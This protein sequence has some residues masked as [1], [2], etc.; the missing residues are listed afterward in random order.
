MLINLLA[1]I[2][3]NRK[4]TGEILMFKQFI[5]ILF[6]LA[7][8][9]ACESTPEKVDVEVQDQG[10]SL[11]EQP[12]DAEVTTLG[13][14]DQDR[15]TLSA[16]DDPQQAEADLSNRTV[17][18]EFDSSDIRYE[19]R[20]TIFVHASYL[21]ANPNTVITLEG[22]ADERGSREYNLALSERRAQTVQRQMNL[23]GAPPQQIRTISY[24]EERPVV[25]EHDEAAWSQNR[26]VEIVY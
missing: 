1:F 5:V 14:S 26:R 24:G 7:F 20:N 19:D 25:E 12:Y 23:L 21:M 8:L 10:R 6:A 16:L 9:S 22:H 15:A 18:F 11:N 17:Y 3:S 4:F 13:A 2:E